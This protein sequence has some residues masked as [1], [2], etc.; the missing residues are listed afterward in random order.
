MQTLIAKL[1]VFVTQVCQYIKF[2]EL[3]FR[4]NIPNKH[5]SLLS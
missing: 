3:H 4:K 2:W 1:D 5:N